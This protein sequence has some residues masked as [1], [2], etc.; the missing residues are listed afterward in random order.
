[1]VLAF[2]VIE[3]PELP[4]EIAYES[5]RASP[6]RCAQ[7]TNF[8]TPFLLRMVNLLQGF[9]WRVLVVVPPIFTHWNKLFQ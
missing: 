5:P 7:K 4:K 6:I 1:V 2:H 9:L 3:N 8:E